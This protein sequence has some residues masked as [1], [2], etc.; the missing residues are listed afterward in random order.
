MYEITRV[1]VGI[2]QTL[3]VLVCFLPLNKTNVQVSHEQVSNPTGFGSWASDYS[4]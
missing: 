2:D 3:V 4:I 1:E